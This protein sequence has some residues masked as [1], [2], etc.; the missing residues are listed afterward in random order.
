MRKCV[1]PISCVTLLLSGPAFAEP[2]STASVK[3]AI[4]VIQPAS[5]STCKG[6]VRFTQEGDGTKVVADIEGLAP[7]SKHGFHV[8]E[9]GDCSA[10]DALSAGSH[11][12]AAGTKHHGMPS[13]AVR[14]TGDMGNI[15][16]DAAGKAHY[17]I[18]LAGAALSGEHVFLVGHAVIVHAKPD[19]FSQPVGNAGGRIGCGVIGI[20]K[21]VN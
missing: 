19:D 10:P 15:E 20:A 1:L 5:G 8:H 11:Y 14:H 7:N 9:F 13:E 4:A 6:I 21:P 18:T 16:A 12:D 2:Q 17:E 3:E